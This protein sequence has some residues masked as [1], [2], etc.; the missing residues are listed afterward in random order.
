V[1][2]T[3]SQVLALYRQPSRKF[4]W[5][6]YLRFRAVPFAELVHAVPPT[7][8][9]LDIGC[10]FGLWLNYL[11][12][13]HPGLTL[14]GIDHDKRKIDVAQT[15]ARPGVGFRLTGSDSPVEGNYDI[16]TLVDVLYLLPPEAKTRLLQQ[17]FGALRP[18]GVLLV[19]EV[20]VRPRWRYWIAAF[21]EFLA[22]NVVRLTKG[23]GI[24]FWAGSQYLQHLD[25]LGFEQ[26][27]TSQL[28]RGYLHPQML[29]TARKP[30]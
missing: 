6:S 29:V 15:S 13:V 5:Y 12:L 25:R 9:L 21:E 27:A 22:V 14:E 18:G 8:S 30:L 24:H 16:I 20:E 26:T 19:K 3:L 23:D 7:G 11:S 4:K 10:G 2:P 28:G 1:S 17:C